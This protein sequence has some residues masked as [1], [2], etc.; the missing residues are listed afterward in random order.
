MRRG[1]CEVRVG[2]WELSRIG[3][4]EGHVRLDG[5][6]RLGSCLSRIL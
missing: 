4:L 2:C 5:E 3:R 1:F 6:W